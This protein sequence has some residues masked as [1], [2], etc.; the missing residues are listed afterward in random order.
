MMNKKIAVIYGDGI[1]IEVVREGVKILKIIEE[2]SDYSIEFIDTPAGGQ[3]WKETGSSLP[4]K[5]FETMKK[6]DAILFG[7][8]GLPGLPQGVAESAI[9]GI[10]QGLKQYVNLRPVKLYE[11]LRDKCPLKD[12]Y[13]GKGID[14]TFVRENSEGL[15]TKIG[16]NVHGDTAVDT[17][18]FTKVGVERIIRYAFEYAKA[19]GHS[20]VTSIDK[21]NILR[22]SQLWR[23]AFTEIGDNEYSTIKKENFYVDAF[24]QWLIRKPYEVQTA[25]TCNMFGDICSDEAAYLIGSLGMAA[26]GNINPEGVSMFE[27]IHGSAPDI[28]GKGIA[29]PIGTILSVKIMMEEAFKDKNIGIQIEKAVEKSLLS[30]RTPDIM[31]ANPTSNI[32]Q[33]NTTEMA[34][35]IGEELKNLMKN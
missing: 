25:V 12:E 11:S 13:I 34:D 15:Y 24:C 4:E 32:K 22:T 26:S 19:K 33:V 17:M 31:P 9:L 6:C 7:A 16:G 23:D 18:V 21:A 20:K 2:F 35:I 8:I 29:N 5:S 27:P 14:I 10:R 3:V 30:G 28:A 1:G